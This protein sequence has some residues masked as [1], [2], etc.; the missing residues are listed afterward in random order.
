MEDNKTEEPGPS[1][2]QAEESTMMHSAVVL[3]AAGK[4]APA[5]PARGTLTCADALALNSADPGRGVFK[6]RE[7]HSDEEYEQYLMGLVEIRERRAYERGR[8]EARGSPWVTL[9]H[10][11]TFIVTIYWTLQG[12]RGLVGGS[13]HALEIQR[14]LA[15]DGNGQLEATVYGLGAYE[16]YPH[17][18]G[19]LY[20]IASPLS[21]VHGAYPPPGGCVRVNGP[22]NSTGD[23]EIVASLIHHARGQEFGA[24]SAPR[25]DRPYCALVSGYTVM[26]NP[27][28]VMVNQNNILTGE[29]TAPL[30]CP[31]D[32]AYALT[33]SLHIVVRYQNAAHEW[34]LLEVRDPA[35][36]WAL[37]SEIAYL[38]HGPSH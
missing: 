29:E 13:N 9:F 38:N 11:F 27:E 6:S 28:I 17:L 20:P 35:T 23:N 1:E 26:L 3:P 12:M 10:I 32:Q 16:A 8:A 31:K 4:S 5:V 15:R 34:L 30:T 14:A 19:A 7:F 33:R 18:Q 24:I 21:L 25:L 37:Q 22:F 36:A 2:T